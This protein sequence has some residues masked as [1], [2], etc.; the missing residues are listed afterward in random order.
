MSHKRF[1]QNP[2]LLTATKQK[3]KEPTYQEQMKAKTEEEEEENTKK[4]R[5][6]SKNFLSFLI[7]GNEL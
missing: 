4:N 3:N 7:T 2:I 1:T 6:D 5:C